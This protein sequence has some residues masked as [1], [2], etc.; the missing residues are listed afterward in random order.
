MADPS[1]TKPKTRA[2]LNLIGLWATMQQASGLLHQVADNPHGVS[3]SDLRN[4]AAELDGARSVL[5]EIMGA[6]RDG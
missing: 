2:G 3:K 5:A 4:A 1:S 6:E